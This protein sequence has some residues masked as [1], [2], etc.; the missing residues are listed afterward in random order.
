MTDATTADTTMTE[1]STKPSPFA[2]YAELFDGANVARAEMERFASVRNQIREWIEQ[3][4]CHYVAVG[5]GRVVRPRVFVAE[6]QSRSGTALLSRLF[7]GEEQY[8]RRLGAGDP[9]VVVLATV[10]EG[11]RRARK[12]YLFRRSEAT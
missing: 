7:P 10:W 4:R 11:R 3:D 5:P 2:P 12:C 6:V 9:I 8:E 1:T